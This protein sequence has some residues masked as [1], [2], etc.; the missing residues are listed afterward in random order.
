MSDPDEA[1]RELDGRMFPPAPKSLPDGYEDPM[2]YIQATSAGCISC[3]GLTD[4][5]DMHEGRNLAISCVDCH[6]GV[7]SEIE[8]LD[9]C[10]CHLRANGTVRD[11]ARVGTAHQSYKGR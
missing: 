2:Q 11:R 3:H 9:F 10:R 4:E 8:S 7:G 5:P 6:G 1:R